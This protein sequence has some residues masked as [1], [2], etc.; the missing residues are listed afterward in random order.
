MKRR[1]RDIINVHLISLAFYKL[2]VLEFRN[3]ESKAKSNIPI[4]VL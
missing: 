3:T 2:Q 1:L 4:P